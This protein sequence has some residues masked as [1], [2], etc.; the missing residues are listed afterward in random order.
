VSHSAW[1][2]SG[3]FVAQPAILKPQIKARGRYQMLRKIL[4]VEDDPISLRSIAAFLRGEGYDV[5]EAHNG[6]EAFDQLL[7]PPGSFD[8]ILTDI[9][10]PSSSGLRLLERTR[11]IT[12]NLPVILMTAFASN[13][14]YKDGISF[15]AD[16]FITKPFPFD[17]LLEK[18]DRAIE[19]RAKS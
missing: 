10:M 3:I 1:Q 5:T 16:D 19:A 9:R 12:P 15:E 18:I 11:V 13:E 4:V 2:P 14:V 17:L 7:T 6:D 8:L